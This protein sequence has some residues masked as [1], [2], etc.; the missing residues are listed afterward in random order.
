MLG[1]DAALFPTLA[2]V[3]PMSAADVTDRITALWRRSG[4][5]AAIIAVRLDLSVIAAEAVDELK[6]RRLEVAFQ[7]LQGDRTFDPAHESAGYLDAATA[8]LNTGKFDVVIFGHTHLPKRIEVAREGKSAGLYINT[9]TWADVI[10]LPDKVSEASAAGRTA[11]RDFLQDM[12][13]H[14]IK[15]HLFTCLGYAEVELAGETVTL[16]ALRS[17]TRA[18]PRAVPMTPYT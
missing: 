10:Q 5:V 11:R 16:S 2:Q 7:A 13:E 18:E 17:F 1:V 9:G 4:E 6:F 12:A 3:A 14:R 15:P 8:I